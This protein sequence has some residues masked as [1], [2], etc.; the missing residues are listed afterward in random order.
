MPAGKGTYG[1]K[2]GRPSKKAMS[3]KMPKEVLA[4]MKAKKG[5]K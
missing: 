1:S 3:K 2:R 4:K 5:K